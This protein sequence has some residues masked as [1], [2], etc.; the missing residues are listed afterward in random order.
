MGP[1]PCPVLSRGAIGSDGLIGPAIITDVETTIVIPPRDV[2][3]LNSTGD[4]VIAIAQ[5]LEV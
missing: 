1:T 3:S 2:A 4:I 5:E